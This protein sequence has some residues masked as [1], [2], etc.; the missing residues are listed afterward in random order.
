[1]KEVLLV[2]AGGGLGSLLRYQLGRIMNQAYLPA[3]PFA[4]LVINIIA[5]F[6]LG[7]LLGYLAGQENQNHPLKLLLAVGFCGGF[8]TF[9][10]FSYETLTLIRQGQ[11]SIAFGNIL[12]SVVLCLGA[13]YIGLLLTKHT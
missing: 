5:S 9:S 1:M 12:L 11:I 2:F 4:T 8:S 3:F 6:I 13:T 10:T 7:C